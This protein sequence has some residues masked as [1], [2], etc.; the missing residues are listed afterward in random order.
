ME[1]RKM[2]CT[3]NHYGKLPDPKANAT[4][5]DFNADEKSSYT[6]KFRKNKISYP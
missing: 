6:T 3:I 2:D 5:V 4:K 1:S